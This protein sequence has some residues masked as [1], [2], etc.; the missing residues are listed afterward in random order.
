MQAS[1]TQSDPLQ[2]GAATNAKA[3]LATLVRTQFGF[4]WRTLRRFGVPQGDADDAAQQVFMVLAR[5][6]CDIEPGAERAFLFGT[7]VRIA[8]RSRRTRQ[9]RREELEDTFDTLLGAS[10]DPEAVLEQRQATELLSAILE[11]MPDDMRAAFV[12]CEVEQL[13]MIEV[14]ELLGVPQGTIASRLRRARE[15]YD[16]AVGRLRKR[17]TGNRGSE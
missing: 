13:T 3:D 9:R 10:P 2:S 12:L 7:A 17:L 15:Q 11:T 16:A 1:L 5:K 8:S 6:H 14:A 4:V